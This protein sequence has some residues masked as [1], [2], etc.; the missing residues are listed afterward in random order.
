ME[1]VQLINALFDS[2]D[3]GY[4]QENVDKIINLL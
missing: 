1:T 4:I 2:I 3:S